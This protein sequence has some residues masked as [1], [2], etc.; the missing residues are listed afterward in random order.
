VNPDSTTRS[1][2]DQAAHPPSPPP[3]SGSSRSTSSLAATQT[4]VAP[5]GWALNRLQVFVVA[6]LVL[7][8]LLLAVRLW[9]VAGLARTVRIEG[10]SMAPAWLGGHY[11][12]TCED[13]GL[14]FKCD[15]EHAPPSGVASCPNCGFRDNLLREENLRPGQ[16]VVIDRWPHL[17]AGPRRGDVVAA[18]DPYDPGS[19][20]V[21]R[22]AGLPGERLA[23]RGGDLFISDEIVRKSLRELAAV[24]VLVHDSRHRPQRSSGLPERWQS[25]RA[26]MGWHAAPGGYRYESPARSKDESFDWLSYHHWLLCASHSR[27]K[28]SPVL[29]HDSYNQAAPREQ[30]A[31]TD[32]LV[33]CRVRTT[34]ASGQFAFAASDGR[35]R[36]EA[37]FD[38]GARTVVLTIDGR[39]A[40][41][42]KLPAHFARRGALIEFGLCDEQVLLSI[43]SR[44]VLRHAYH[45]PRGEQ[46]D[47]LH[48]LA[49]GTRGIGLEVT[50][51]VVWRDVYYLPPSGLAGEWHADQPLAAG[52]Y[53]LLG[54][55]TTVSIDSR[56]WSAGVPAGKILGRVYGP[57]WRVD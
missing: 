43:A 14:E 29:D 19:F 32:V 53:A 50:D 8:A 26:S 49:I 18:A 5:A 45:R 22:V 4:V 33:S 35:Q 23:I 57:F 40:A 44:E 24:R 15:A 6:V 16:Q 25:D 27:T 36:F 52:C 10:P 11:Q 28:L 56:Q 39:E 20:V 2:A 7:L 38:P 9:A 3:L 17:F 31:V 41:R 46:P 37:A 42:D 47:P 1:V 48:P 13:C 12:V 21:K 34:S 54:D 51:L 55:N 30:N